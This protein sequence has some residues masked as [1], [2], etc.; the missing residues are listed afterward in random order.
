MR[1][2]QYE[3][4]NGNAIIGG[5]VMRDLRGGTSK[6][7]FLLEDDLPNDT[8]RRDAV[9]PRTVRRP[10]VRQIAGLGGAVGSVREAFD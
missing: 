10:D 5:R 8:K 9:A 6:P 2:I 4:V 7:I 3:I 1:T